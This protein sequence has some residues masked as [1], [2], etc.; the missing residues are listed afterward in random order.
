MVE[1]IR[2]LFAPERRAP[3]SIA[4]LLDETHDQIVRSIWRELET[5]LGIKHIFAN[6][7]PHI[8]HLQA[9]E[10]KKPDIY[11]A[12]ENFAENQGPYTLRTVGLG[13]FT[14]ENRAVYISVVRTPQLAAVQTTLTSALAGSI[15]GIR[16]T[17]FINNWMPH[18]SLLLPGM[19]GEQVGA[20]V[21]LLAKRDYSWEFPITRLAIL[22]GNADDTE[23]PYIAQLKGGQHD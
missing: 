6:P 22:D 14:G 8:T 3:C 19:V 4:A 5:E 7:V 9:Q 11:A 15:E 20:I 21:D 12:L 18:I 23:Q 1:F 2:N 16:Q 13:I 17:H 10:I